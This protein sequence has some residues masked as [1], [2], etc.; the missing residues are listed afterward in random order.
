MFYLLENWPIAFK[1]I[2]YCSKSNHWY[3]F[4]VATAN[5]RWLQINVS[6]MSDWCPLSTHN[7]NWHQH[8]QKRSLWKYFD[9]KPRLVTIT[10]QSWLVLNVIFSLH[11]VDSVIQMET[12]TINIGNLMV[13]SQIYLLKQA[14]NDLHVG[15]LS[16]L[17]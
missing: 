15:W 11:Q 7:I 17:L 5:L 2:F 4:T 9:I 1:V 16:D 6:K 3:I 8:M 13:L 14:W 12:S 10:K